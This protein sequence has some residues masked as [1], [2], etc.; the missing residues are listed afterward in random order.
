MGG[1]PLAGA[2]KVARCRC[3]R[4]QIIRQR[5]LDEPAPR[6]ISIALPR[7]FF[8]RIPGPAKWEISVSGKSGRVALGRVFSHV[9]CH[10]LAVMRMKGRGIL[11]ERLI[12]GPVFD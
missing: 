12:I 3:S 7:E 6:R 11:D 5:Q 4:P 10:L 8:R 9:V 2:P 1:W